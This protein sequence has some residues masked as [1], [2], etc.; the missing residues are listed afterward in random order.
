MHDL[1]GLVWVILVVIGVATSIIK[2]VN[3]TRA[4]GSPQMR[5]QR[6]APRVMAS[7]VP[8]VTA[9]A[10]APV[11]VGSPNESMQEHR[12]ARARRA[13]RVLRAPETDA[14]LVLPASFHLE[15]VPG[16]RTAGFIG[17]MFKDRRAFVRAI[18]AAEVLG[19][20]IALQEQSIWSPRRSEPSI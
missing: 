4:Q 16:R 3:K 9:P 13:T 14:G 2:N 7:A 1:G 12:Q 20:P 17:G 8:T 18:V 19:K 6:I 10:T 15:Y 11:V 5:P